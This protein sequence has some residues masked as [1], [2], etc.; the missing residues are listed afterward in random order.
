MYLNLS[1]VQL[2]CDKEPIHRRRARWLIITHEIYFCFFQFYFFKIY[3]TNL[4]DTEQ[5][6]SRK[7]AAAGFTLLGTAFRQGRLSLFTHISCDEEVSEKNR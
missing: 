4:S 1:D 3:L 2:V 5:H 7:L 6:I